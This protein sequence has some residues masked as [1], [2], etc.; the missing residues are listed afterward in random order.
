MSHVSFSEL[1]NWDKCAFY[2][3]LMHV[4]KLKLFKGNE[5]TAFGTAIHDTCENMLLNEHLE[6]SDFFLEK[7]KE[8]LKKLADDD[9]EFDKKLA[10]DM[11][12]QGLEI[13][14]YIKPA[15]N[16]Y[17][18]K[19]KIFSTEEKLFENVEINDYKYK[20]YIDLVL[21]TSDGKYHIIDWKS[22]SWGWNSR[23][24]TERMT[25]YQLTFY[26]YYFAKKHNI[27]LDNVETH[28]ALLK[29]TAQDNKVEIFKV[30]S[31]KKKIKNALN[32]L[33][34]AM[35]NIINKKYIKNKLA[36]HGPF[37]TCE[38]YKTKHCP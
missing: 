33:N 31:G 32:F 1:K 24:K 11:K 21:Q 27:D 5:Y 16:S 10:L 13:L 28:F 15:L 36:C 23:R 3:K 37:G 22:C 25:T 7:Y 6:V 2:H 9:Y 34:K 19:Y 26:K 4:D 30:S 38:F 18:S 8:S 29:R 20:G 35:Y 12:E 17:F 14:P